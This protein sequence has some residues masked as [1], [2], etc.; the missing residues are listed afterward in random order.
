MKIDSLKL[1]TQKN[2]RSIFTYKNY[3]EKS[4]EIF[5]LSRQIENVR[6]LAN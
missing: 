1:G 4:R 5:L 2:L 3:L 6:F